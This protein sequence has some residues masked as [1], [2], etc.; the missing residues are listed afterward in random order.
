METQSFVLAKRPVGLPDESA[1]KLKRSSLKDELKD[2]EL[3][4]HGLFYSVDPYMRGRM[5]DAKSY[6]EPFILDQPINGGVVARVSESK[7]PDFKKGDLVLGQLPWATEMIVSSSQVHKIN[8]TEKLASEYL[9]VLGMTGLTAYFGLL[10]IGQPKAGETVIISGAAG[11]VGCVVGQIA[12]IKG[13]KVVGIVGT[14]EKAKLLKNDFHFDETINYNDATDLASLVKQACPDG[15]DIFYDNVGGVISDAIIPNINFHG[16]IVLCGQ[17]ALYNA[18]EI[19]MGPRIQP[20]L[21][22]RS[23]LMQGFTIG[24]FS[25]HFAEGTAALD[26]WLKEGKLKSSQTIVEGFAEL[27]KALLGLFSGKNIGKMI[28]KAEN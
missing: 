26:G 18:K 21:L 20:Y 9:G 24:N 14:N 8:T 12:K 7:D 25:E 4:L 13:C 27:P 2:K 19:P 28:V 1:F 10:K 23:I 22:T 11:A 15:I 16:R 5:N 17:I 6:V 3:N